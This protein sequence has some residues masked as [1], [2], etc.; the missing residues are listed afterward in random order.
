MELQSTMDYLEKINVSLEN[1]E[2]FV[3]L[4]IVQ[5]PTIGEITKQGFVEGWKKARCE[6]TKKQAA[7]VKGEIKRLSTDIALFKRVYK[8]AFI[9]GR[10]KDQKALSLDNALTFWGTLF[11][12]PGWRWVGQNHD[13]LALWKEFLGEK[14]TRSVNKDMWNMTLEFALK[15]VD[16][17]SLSFWSED[18]AWPSVIDDFVEWCKAKGVTKVDAMDATA[19]M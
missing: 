6:D 5:A 8:H 12:E 4:E 2:L 14:W 13:W 15:S 16:D 3:A 17:E 7:F 19:E 11:A 10:E 1:V 9:A 18:G